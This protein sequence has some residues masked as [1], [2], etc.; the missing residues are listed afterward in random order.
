[1]LPTIT[2]VMSEAARTGLGCRIM[3]ALCDISAFPP[4]PSPSVLSSRLEVF[5]TLLWSVIARFKDQWVL[6]KVCENVQM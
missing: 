4:V 2:S 5:T 6:L 1:M 3:P